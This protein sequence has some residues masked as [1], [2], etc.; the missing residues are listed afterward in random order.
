MQAVL[1]ARFHPRLPH[2]AGLA[3]LLVVAADILLYGA[4]PGISAA[5][6]AALLG[7]GIWYANRP[8]LADPAVRSAA[9]MAVA[10]CLALVENVSWLSASFALAGL[11]S[12]ALPWRADWR[13]E[14]VGWLAMLLAFATQAW[15]RPIRDSR[16]YRIATRRTRQFVVRKARL[17]AWVLPLG[18]S[19]IFLALFA[20]ANP[21]ISDWLA[22]LADI[23]LPSMHRVLFWVLAAFL[24]WPFIRPRLRRLRP[25]A[26]M[27]GPVKAS[28]GTSLIDTL[29]SR[30][31]VLRSLVIFNTI[32]AVQTLLDATY[33]WGGLALPDGMTYAQY[34]HRGAYPLVAAAL[35]AAGFVLIAMRPGSVSLRDPL[36]RLLV[37]GW[38]TQ[39]V[40]LVGASIW[41]TGL[42][43]SVYSLTY[44]RVAA[45]LWMIL[46]AAGLV[47]ILLRMALDKS[48]A[49]L[50]RVNMLTAM[51]ML[52]ALCF[53]DVGGTIARFNVEHSLAVREQGYPLDLDYLEEIGPAALP[54]L[55]RY[56]KAAGA[57]W[58]EESP[59][60]YTRFIAAQSLRTGLA[61]RLTQQHR[62]W[63]NYSFRSYR[64]SLAV[65]KQGGEIYD[66]PQLGGG[67]R[68]R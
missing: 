37:Y 22:A 8:S 57:K 67:W 48:N 43:V 51:A 60:F 55:D 29:F 15:L 17:I 30:D 40:I 46:V 58:R 39:T 38:V 18:A 49:W 42:Y 23:D 33:L 53:V 12:L 31:A 14:G 65:A 47:W 52:Y 68:I 54:A 19:M 63:R 4:A 6:F 7:G 32:F 11:V 35:L 10:G 45:V 59:E 61:W 9:I 56:I 28:A 2:K 26:T 27:V 41:R 36:V 16:F 21:I 13:R 20:D 50:V 1:D 25:H 44:L 66:A 3:V 5:I 24:C 62:D 64:L 34:A